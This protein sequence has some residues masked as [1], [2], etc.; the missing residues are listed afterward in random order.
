MS[1]HMYSYW[2]LRVRVQVPIVL[3][4]LPTWG[5]SRGPGRSQE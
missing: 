2:P 5:F 3:G 1:A 4:I